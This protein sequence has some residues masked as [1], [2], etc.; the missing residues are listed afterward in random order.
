MIV[1]WTAVE[2]AQIIGGSL[3]SPAEGSPQSFV[4]DSREAGSGALFFGIP[5]E[6]VD[7]GDYAAAVLDAGAWGVIVSSAGADLLEG[8]RGAVIEHPDPVRALGLLA[9]KRL[10]E[11]GCSVIMITGSTGKTSTKDITASLISGA[12]RTFASRE[13]RNTEIGMPLEVLSAP[14]DT[15]VMVLEAAMRGPGQISELVEIAKPDVGVVTNIGP[16]H[17][18]LLGSIEAIASAKSELITGL[19]P[20]RTAVVPEGE[21]LIAPFLRDDLSTLTFG[22][23]GRV[24]LVHEEG[25]RL[26]LDLDGVQHEIEVSFDQPHNRLN[27]L[28]GAAAAHAIGVQPPE[29]IDVGFSAFRGQ[30][31]EIAD[32]VVVIDDC[33]NANPMSM[34]AALEDLAGESARRGGRR[35]AVLGDMLE[36]GPHGER[37]HEETGRAASEF[38]VDVLVTVGELAAL[39]AKGF[40]G[41]VHATTDARHAADVVPSL[42]QAGDTVL[43]KASRGIGLEAVSAA[44]R[45][46]GR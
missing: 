4:I 28:A 10:E 9:R 16:V 1:G 35:V 45:D 11:I 3:V 8:A 18:E 14:L 19:E 39:M 2:V 32:G 29:R 40:D 34:R 46:G 33:Y 17:L 44:L 24:R 12:R 13:N 22:P 43:V 38:K 36:L 42:L 25:R 15:E 6:R 20:G 26:T 41:E 37:L 21:A 7:G 5:G 30:R 27:L 23:G 31:F